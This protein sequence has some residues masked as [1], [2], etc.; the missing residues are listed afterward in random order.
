M[1][2][3]EGTEHQLKKKKRGVGITWDRRNHCYKIEGRIVKGPVLITD[4]SERDLGDN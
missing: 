4:E 2:K 3:V 1:R